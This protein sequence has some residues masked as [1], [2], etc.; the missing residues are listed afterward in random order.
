MTRMSKRCKQQECE[1]IEPR[2]SR[3]YQRIHHFVPGNASMMEQYSTVFFLG[4]YSVSQ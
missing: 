2:L 1:L 4:I 3:L